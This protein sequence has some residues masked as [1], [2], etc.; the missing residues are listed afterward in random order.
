MAPSTPICHIPRV[1]S[2]FSSPFFFTHH[3]FWK[4]C[5]KRIL[6]RECIKFRDLGEDPDRTAERKES[7]TTSVSLYSIRCNSGIE[8]SVNFSQKRMP[9]SKPERVS[10]GQGRDKAQC[11]SL[12][13]LVAFRKLG[14]C[15]NWNCFCGILQSSARPMGTLEY[16]LDPLAS[17]ELNCERTHSHREPTLPTTLLQMHPLGGF[18]VLGRVLGPWLLERLAQEPSQGQVLAS[19]WPGTQA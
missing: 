1:D 11:G 15:W 7:G 6:P 14:P 4:D 12:D 16:Q 10:E 13:S 2:P 17:A 3:P 19:S 18:G 9:D 8:I 5:L